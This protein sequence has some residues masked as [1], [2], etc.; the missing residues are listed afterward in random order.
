MTTKKSFKDK[1]I[2][3]LILNAGLI[4]TA[5]GIALFKTPNHFALGG[6]SG[7]AILLADVFPSLHMGTFMFI[8]NV[9]LLVLGLIFV[10]KD[11]AFGTAYSSVMLSVYVA[12]IEFFV[13]L[14][15][16]LTHDPLLELV[17]AVILPAVGSALVFNIGASTGG[18]DIVA[19]IL[20]RHSSLPI[21]MALLATDAVITV[22]TF[23]LFDVATGLYC[24]LGLIMK[25]FLVDLVIDGINSRKYITIIS[26]EPETIE[27]F[28]IERLNRSATISDAEGAYSHQH[29]KVITTVLTRRQA[30]MLRNYIKTVDSSAFIT[31]VNSSQIIGKGF[32]D[33]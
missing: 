2:W 1:L 4:V 5:A 28:I 25:T 33:I 8:I 30:V 3:F 11:F 9:A 13:P 20:A 16:P 24:V 14:K 27:R 19:M 21:G 10:G 7:L 17:W 23:W 26:K 22:A 18:T 12:I 6:T 31:M 32:S 29:E 15:G